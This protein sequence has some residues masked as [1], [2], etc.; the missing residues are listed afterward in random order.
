M[1]GAHTGFQRWRRG[2]GLKFP[3]D[4][5]RGMNL[6][7]QAV[8]RSKILRGVTVGSGVVEYDSL[9]GCLESAPP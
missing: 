3:T 9:A 8:D 5:G 7:R 1:W 2:R 4:S 6:Y